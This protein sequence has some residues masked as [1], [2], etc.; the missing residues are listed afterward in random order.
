MMA[1]LAH[2]GVEGEVCLPE[3]NKY[4]TF[5]VK[6][7]QLYKMLRR[8]GWYEVRQTGSHRIMKHQEHSGHL[9]VPF[10]GSKEVPKGL[11]EATLKKAGLKKR[12]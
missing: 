3:S 2:E 10:H 11:F 6:A 12:K 7:S 5:M 9:S 1:G 8:A 4:I